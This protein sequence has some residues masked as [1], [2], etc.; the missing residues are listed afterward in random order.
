MSLGARICRASP[1]ATK[2][3][4]PSGRIIRID[5]VPAAKVKTSGSVPLE[6]NPEAAPI[7]REWSS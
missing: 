4:R 2:Q 1:L 7:S 5:Q 6:A 3:V